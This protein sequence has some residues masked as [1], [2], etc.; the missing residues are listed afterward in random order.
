MIWLILIFFV[1]MAVMFPAVRCVFRH[2]IKTVVYGCVDIFYYIYHKE[3][4][5]VHTGFIEGFIG[6]FGKGKTLN[7]THKVVGLYQKYNGK[8][9]WDS[10]NERF[11]TQRIVV[12]SN[13]DLPTIPHVKL[14]DLKQIIDFTE[15]VKEQDE[16]YG[17]YTVAL[18]EI[19]EASVQMNSRNFKQNIDA[20]FLNALLTCRHF[21]MNMYYSAQRFG[22]VD[23]LLRQVTSYVV[24]CSKNWRLQG[25]EYYDAWEMENATNVLL[26]KPFKRD[27]WFVE[28]K[29]YGNYNT[30]ATV[31][32]LRKDCVNGDML[33]EE[34]IL[35]LQCNLDKANT[36]GIVN[37]SKKLKKASK[38]IR[39]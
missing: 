37:P 13:V 5:K 7:M 38:K 20:L 27:C 19:D 10:E 23:A 21:H 34:K 15:N 16:K 31:G 2:P 29:D 9:V 8:T 39:K 17:T 1:I 35:A 6:L 30:F 14:I 4:N 24:Y 22:Q 26:L 11:A 28:N 3:Y 12:F 25:V 18:I 33:D 36:D 32:N